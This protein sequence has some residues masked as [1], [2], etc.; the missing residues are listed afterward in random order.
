MNG[1]FWREIK[2]SGGK[3]ICQIPA[4]GENGHNGYV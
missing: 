4:L 3:L 2:Y 1:K